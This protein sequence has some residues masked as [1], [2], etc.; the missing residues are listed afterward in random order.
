MARQDVTFL[1]KSPKAAIASDLMKTLEEPTAVIISVFQ[2]RIK[3][4]PIISFDQFY[5]FL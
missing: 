5:Y 2:I 1:E 4:R 3:G